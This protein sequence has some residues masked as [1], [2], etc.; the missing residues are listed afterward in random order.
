MFHLNVLW[1]E[2]CIYS[3]KLL[4]FMTTDLVKQSLVTIQPTAQKISIMEILKKKQF[5]FTFGIDIRKY[6]STKV[7]NI[8][9]LL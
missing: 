3:S 4:L 5:G 8:Y 9:E 7:E 1:L 6:E 2:Y